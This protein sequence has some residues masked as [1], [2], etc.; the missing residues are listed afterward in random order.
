MFAIQNSDIQQEAI[1]LNNEQLKT[2]LK[3]QANVLIDNMQPHVATAMKTAAGVVFTTAVNSGGVFL[4][5]STLTHCPSM[6]PCVNTSVDSSTVPVV[7]FSTNTASPSI[8]YG[9]QKTCDLAKK[10]MHKSIDVGVDVSS[11]SFLLFSNN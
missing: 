3:E 1:V 10:G 7:I 11:R 4:K 8:D 9:V 2:S 5:A 6:A